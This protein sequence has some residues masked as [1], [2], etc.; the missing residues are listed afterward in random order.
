M[1][2][3]TKHIVFAVIS[4]LIVLGIFTVSNYESNPE[5][6][7]I[8]RVVDDRDE[9]QKLADQMAR[10]KR[11]LTEARKLRVEFTIQLEDTERIV[12]SIKRELKETLKL[13]ED[14]KGSILSLA[15]SMVA[16]PTSE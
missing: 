12:I 8:E 5:V 4:A 16:L 1:I 2:M 10:F 11:Q 3:K 6:Y 14:I 13:E 9:A 7:E 15:D